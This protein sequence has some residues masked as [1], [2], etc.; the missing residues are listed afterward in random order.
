MT[1]LHIYEDSAFSLGV[2][3]L[4]AGTSIPL[5]DHPDMNV[6]SHLLFGSLHVTAYDRASDPPAD[7]TITPS[8]SQQQEISSTEGRSD[9][10]QTSS[11]SQSQQ[12]GSTTSSTTWSKVTAGV[13]QR[14]SGMLGRPFGKEDSGQ[15]EGGRFWA[16]LKV[17]TTVTAPTSTMLLQPNSKC[18]CKRAS[19]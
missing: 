11:Q 17:D 7:T 12:R 1:Y 14:F 15:Q 19:L 16:E 2:F 5:H 9:P 3:M 10:G 4:P 6:I 8:S 18:N 13:K